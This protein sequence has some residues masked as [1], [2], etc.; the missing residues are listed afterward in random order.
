M[1]G[2][3]TTEQNPSEVKTTHIGATL[4]E[5]FPN[6]ISRMEISNK[7]GD[8]VTKDHAVEICKFIFDANEGRTTTT[9]IVGNDTA[10]VN[11]GFG[12]PQEFNVNEYLSKIRIAEAI[13]IDSAAMRLIMNFYTALKRKRN[14]KI[15]KNESE[16]QLWLLEELNNHR[17]S[18]NQSF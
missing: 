3:L 11:L 13:V 16:A 14:S 4:V 9:M 5:V 15:F 6:G 12:V 10:G 2:H 1:N 17:S 7:F 8:E 18:E